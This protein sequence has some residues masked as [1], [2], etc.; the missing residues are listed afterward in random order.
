MRFIVLLAL[1]LALASLAATTAHA[2]GPLDTDGDGSTDAREQSMG[3]NELEVC[4]NDRIP[5][6]ETDAWPPDADD[7]SDADVGDVIQLFSGHVP[8]TPPNTYYVRADFDADGDNDI[9]DVLIWNVLATGQETTIPT[10]CRALVDHVCQGTDVMIVSVVDTDPK[11]RFGIDPGDLLI[12]FDIYVVNGSPNPLI[13]S[14]DMS[15][16][17][18][19]GEL[20]DFSDSLPSTS[21]IWRTIWFDLTEEA[22]GY[23]EL[24][25]ITGA[26][27]ASAYTVGE[28]Y[29][30]QGSLLNA[31]FDSVGI[32]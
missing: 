6:N 3:T 13:T 15:S 14:Q 16:S 5:G 22:S 32:C 11:H 27:G 9:G 10:T 29:D 28:L 19:T 25:R 2:G 26:D 24:F 7:D 12:G 31:D 1:A 8:S 18:L 17:M 23:G 30:P 20:A 4:P 21:V